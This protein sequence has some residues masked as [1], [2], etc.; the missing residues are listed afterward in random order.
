MVSHFL[1]E[2]PHS[3]GYNLV[4]TFSRNVHLN[5]AAGPGVASAMADDVIL[6][7]SPSPCHL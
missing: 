3:R 1:D 2:E 4:Q 6:G 5:R 7:G